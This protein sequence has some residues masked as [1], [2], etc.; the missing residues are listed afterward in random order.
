MQILTYPRVNNRNL[1]KL[2]IFSGGDPGF[3]INGTP[4]RGLP[5]V[6][7]P[8]DEIPRAGSNTLRNKMQLQQTPLSETSL[9]VNFVYC[10]QT[11]P[12]DQA[13]SLLSL[14]KPSVST[15]SDIVSLCLL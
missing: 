3:C 13:R 10:K 2:W 1:Y 8:L 6:I 5:L 7:S 12:S 15:T 9:T 14:K 11:S 4:P